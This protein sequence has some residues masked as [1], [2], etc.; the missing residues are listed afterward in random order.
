M[1]EKK[2]T[3]AFTATIQEYLQKRADEDPLFAEALKKEGKSIDE[4]ITYIFNTVKKSGSIGFTDDEVFSM[5]VHYYDEDKIDIGKPMQCYVVVNHQVELTEADKKEARDL[6]LKE[7]VNKEM[8]RMST[9]PKPAASKK[10]EIKTDPTPS[11][12]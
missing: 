3:R 4:C 5:A 9:A 7:L 11:L 6:A 10:P 2:G 12:F 8:A 1:S